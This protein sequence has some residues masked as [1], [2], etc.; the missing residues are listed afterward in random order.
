MTNVVRM[1]GTEKP[2]HGAPNKCV[3]GACEKALEKAKSGELQSIIGTGFTADGMR[4]SFWGGGHDNVYEMTGS[5]EWLKSE[6]M[7]QRLMPHG[8]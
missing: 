4:F 1:D 3:I 8:D 6:Y 7:D 5:L 2:E